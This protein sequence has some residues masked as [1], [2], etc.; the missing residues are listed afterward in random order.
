MVTP[1][2]RR[3]S[4]GLTL[5][6]VLAILV[7]CILVAWVF[8]L[9]SLA[10]RPRH[11]LRIACVHNLKQV[12]LAMKLFANDHNDQYPFQVASSNGGTKEWAGTL[13]VYR[14]F[15]ILGNELGNPK[16]LRCPS[17]KERPPAADYP[18]FGPGNLSYSVALNAIEKGPVTFLLGDRNLTRNNVLLNNGCYLVSTQQVLGWETDSVHKG[19]GNLAFI[20]GSTKQAQ[21]GMLQSLRLKVGI[22]TNWLAV[23]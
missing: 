10:N 3:R 9:P 14:H 12:T 21:P 17:D 23:P 15:Q 22:P 7:V 6:E 2:K 1:D 20:D 13:A 16:V 18:S 8:I 4:V 5:T 11:S 19:A